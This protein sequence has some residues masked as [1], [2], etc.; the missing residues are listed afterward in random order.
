[1]EKVTNYKSTN[2]L[3]GYI[4]SPGASEATTPGIRTTHNYPTLKGLNLSRI[5]GY[6]VFS[7]ETGRGN[8]YPGY[9]SL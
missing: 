6:N 4:N 5:P 3:Q 8:L 2:P 7:V 1:M 9:H